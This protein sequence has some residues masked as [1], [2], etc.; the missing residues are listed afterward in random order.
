MKPAGLAFRPERCPCGR[1]WEVCPRR[2][3]LEFGPA[4][5]VEPGPGSISP[6]RRPKPLK[7]ATGLLCVI[8]ALASTPATAAHCAQGEIW[9]VHLDQCVDIG[10]VLAR[11]YVRPPHRIVRSP[12]R[13]VADADQAPYPSPSPASEPHDDQATVDDTFLLP[14]LEDGAPAI[15]R[16]C[17]AAPNLCR[18]SKR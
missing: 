1:R 4:R 7:P 6:Y 16:L 8:M 2:S 9:R 12:V 14:A 18:T 3:E 13:H 5:A 17:Q 15:W 10:S 11:A